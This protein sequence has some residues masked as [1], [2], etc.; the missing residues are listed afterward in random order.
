[1]KWA[2]KCDSPSCFK[3]INS[4][5]CVSHN[6]FEL[7]QC[8]HPWEW[9]AL[10]MGRTPTVTGVEKEKRKTFWNSWCC[11]GAEGGFGIKRKK[12]NYCFGTANDIVGIVVFDSECG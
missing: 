8:I 6:S 5:S 11:S 12:A 1:M 4:C 10:I 3:A 7:R 9:D 2:I